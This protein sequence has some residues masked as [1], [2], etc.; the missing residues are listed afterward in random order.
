LPSIGDNEF[1]IDSL[2]ICDEAP[3]T[4]LGGHGAI[5]AYVM[6]KLGGQ[7]ILCSAIG[8]DQASD[9]VQQW[10]LQ[11]GVNLTGLRTDPMQ[12]T[13]STTVITDTQLNRLSFHH[14]GA[15]KNYKSEHLPVGILD[16]AEAI[17]LG[18][19]TLLPQWRPYGFADVAARARQAGVTTMLNIG[20]AIGKPATFAELRWILPNIDYFVCNEYELAVCVG[21]DDLEAG[22]EQILA[23]DASCV[24]VTRGEQGALYRST[25]DDMP[26]EVAGFAVQPRYTVGAGDSFNAGL[27]YGLHQKWALSEAVRFANGVAALVVSGQ[28]GTLGAPTLDQVRR[29]MG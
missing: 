13:A 3:T 2:A 15:S 4:V 6:A 27:L 14:P 19:Y 16:D 20:P 18:S 11:A 26:Q 24:V 12:A 9:I 8:Q 22:I 25:D 29:F 5:G 21:T 1:T 17:M 7:S 28:Q 10:L 23:A